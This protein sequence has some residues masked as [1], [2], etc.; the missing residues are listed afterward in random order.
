M[1]HDTFYQ[2]ASTAAQ[3]SAEQS[4]RRRLENMLRFI[5]ARVAI[6]RAAQL[7]LVP[8]TAPRGSRPYF[9]QVQS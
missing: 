9:I 2:R 1:G 4:A 6:A 3:L 7:E 5:D 8:D